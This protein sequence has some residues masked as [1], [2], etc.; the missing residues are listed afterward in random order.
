MRH[1]SQEIFDLR[2]DTKYVSRR[3][4]RSASP[5]TARANRRRGPD[6]PSDS[7]RPKSATGDQILSDDL[8]DPWPD[9]DFERLF[10]W[11]E[12]A[13]TDNLREHWACQPGG[14]DKWGSESALTWSQGKKTRRVCLG[15][16]TCDEPTCEVVTRP[17]TRRAGI[18]GQLNASCRCG[19]Q[20][21]HVDCGVMSVLYSYKGGVYYIHKGVHHHPKQTHILHL[22][23]DER[24]RFEQKVFEN[25][26]AGPGALIAGRHSLTAL[27]V[28]EEIAPVK[29]RPS[30]PAEECAPVKRRRASKR[31]QRGRKRK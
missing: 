31:V 19:G 2:T 29:R 13:K 23:R 12:V 28:E 5:S 26:D 4:T 21:T 30:L 7:L 8:W 24:A 25:P 14:G 11:E 9:G 6:R 18:M 22:S 17:Q 27:P 3:R 10:T 16:I 15:V 1:H 20:L